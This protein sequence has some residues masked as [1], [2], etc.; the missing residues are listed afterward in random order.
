M[1]ETR[2]VFGRVSMFFCRRDSRRLLMGC[3]VLTGLCGGFES[4]CL[5]G[6][7]RRSLL[8]LSYRLHPINQIFWNLLV[9]NEHRHVNRQIN[10]L[11]LHGNVLVLENDAFGNAVMLVG[12]QKGH[13]NMADIIFPRF[14]FNGEQGRIMVCWKSCNAVA[15]SKKL[16]S[17]KEAAFSFNVFLRHDNEQSVCFALQM[18]IFNA[19]GLQ[20]RTNGVQ[21]AGWLLLMKRL[22]HHFLFLTRNVVKRSP[23]APT[24]YDFLCLFNH[25]AGIGF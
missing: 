13:G 12:Q 22:R 23:S 17:T 9:F 16:I 3:V 15:F 25:F 6:C 14:D 1:I 10:G 7:C 5:S 19:F 21:G 2:F 24:R 20:I 8:T 11:V 4:V 18:L